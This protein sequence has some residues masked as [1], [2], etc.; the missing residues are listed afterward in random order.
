MPNARLASVT[1]PIDLYYEE[2]GRGFPLIWWHEYG[3]DYRSWEQQVR[4]FSRRYRVVE[5]AHRARRSRGGADDRPHGEHRGAGT[6]QPARGR[7]PHLGRERTLRTL[8]RSRAMSHYTLDPAASRNN[9]PWMRMKRLTPS[10][11]VVA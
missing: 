9:R 7:V 2:T 1:G 8:E 11:N 5:E 3:G 4:Y 10:L 6:V